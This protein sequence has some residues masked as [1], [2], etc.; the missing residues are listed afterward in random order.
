MANAEKAEMYHFFSWTWTPIIPAIASQRGVW[1]I[2]TFSP[3]PTIDRPVS[4]RLAKMLF[5]TGPRNCPTIVRQIILLLKLIQNLLNLPNLPKLT[6]NLPKTY[7]KLTQ[8]LPKTYPKTDPKNFMY[9]QIVL[10]RFWD[11]SIIYIINL[12]IRVHDKKK[13]VLLFMM[14]YTVY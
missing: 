1:C 9:I 6:Q 13:K 5:D 8:N 4:F 10:T 12:I 7:P 11:L 2:L 14:V 3:F